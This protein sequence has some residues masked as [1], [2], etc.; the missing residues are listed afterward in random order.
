MTIADQTLEQLAGRTS[1]LARQRADHAR[2]DRIMA[3]ARETVETGGV[4]HQ[5]AL[6]AVAQLVFTHAS[7]RS[8]CCSPPRA[9]S[10]PRGTR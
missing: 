10:C 7:P 6:R 4:A 9:R 2:L 3:R 1:I 5:V 8:P